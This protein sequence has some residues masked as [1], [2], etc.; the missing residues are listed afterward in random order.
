MFLY[1]PYIHSSHKICIQFIQSNIV[2]FCG[3]M[4]ANE[5]WIKKYCVLCSKTY[6]TLHS[7]HN[8]LLVLDKPLGVPASVKQVYYLWSQFSKNLCF[9]NLY[10]SGCF[11]G[12]R[13]ITWLPLCYCTGAIGVTLKDISKFEIYIPNHNKTQQ[14]VNYMLNDKEI[15]ISLHL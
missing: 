1:G 3:Q 4:W 10:S 6:N 9:L 12:I 14:S 11:T 13:E 15:R 2:H 8:S 5:V 7:C